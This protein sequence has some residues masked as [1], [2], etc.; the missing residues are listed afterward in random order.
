MTQLGKISKLNLIPVIQLSEYFLYHTQRNCNIAR[1]SNFI[2]FFFKCRPFWFGTLSDIVINILQ[3][4]FLLH[5][6]MDFSE[7]LKAWNLDSLFFYLEISA[8]LTEL[9]SVV[10]VK[11]SNL[12]ICRKFFAIYVLYHFHMYL[13]QILSFIMCIFVK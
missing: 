7:T 12:P 13:R 6:C 4:Q 11:R 10:K 9:F 8:F 1:Y 5:F 3:T 2:G